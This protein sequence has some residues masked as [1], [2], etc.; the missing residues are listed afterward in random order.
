M[1]VLFKSYIS[2]HFGIHASLPFDVPQC[3]SKTTASQEKIMFVNNCYISLTDFFVSK[4]IISMRRTNP[5]SIPKKF[6]EGEWAQNWIHSTTETSKDLAFFLKGISKN[7][8]EC[9]GENSYFRQLRWVFCS[10]SAS[11]AQNNCNGFIGMIYFLKFMAFYVSD[12]KIA[13]IFF[14]SF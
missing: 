12:I 3:S 8:K 13:R 2:W 5:P 4:N 14:P 9:S 10:R 7:S 11:I 1:H 6:F